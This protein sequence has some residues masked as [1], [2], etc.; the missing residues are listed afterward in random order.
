MC[1]VIAFGNTMPHEDPHSDRKSN[2]HKL[3]DRWDGSR[4]TLLKA[5]GASAVTF[6]ALGV[7]TASAEQLDRSNWS[8]SASDVYDS[9]HVPAYAIGGGE[10]WD[11]YSSGESQ[12]DGLWFEVDLGS[13]N[14]FDEL[15]MDCTDSGYPRNFDVQVSDDGSS[16]TTVDS[17]S[18][19][20][21]SFTFSFAS[22]TSR[23]FRLLVTSSANGNWLSINDLWLNDT[24]SS[25]DDDGDDGDD[26]DGGSSDDWF[27]VESDGTMTDPEGNHWQAQ[28]VNINGE[29]WVWP[30][31]NTGDADLMMDCWNFNF[32]RVCNIL[33]DQCR[34]N[35][36]F[37]DNNDIQD[38]IDTF[39]AKNAVVMLDEHC[40][41]G[42]YYEDWQVDEIS[43]YF[44][45]WADANPDNPYL[46][47][48]VANEPGGSDNDFDLWESHVRQI[49]E[50]VR[51]AG[52]D[53][54]IA[55]PGMSWGQDTGGNWSCETVGESD[56]FILDRGPSIVADYDNVIMD[57][58]IYDQWEQC[59]SKLETFLDDVQSKG[60]HV[61]AGE[62]GV[63]NNGDVSDAFDYFTNLESNYD[64]LSWAAWHWYGGDDNELCTSGDPEPGGYAIDDCTS[65]SNLTWF[66]EEIWDMTH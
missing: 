49:I 50:D 5:L 24:G 46:W 21:G 57:F 51:A 28:G 13:E 33:W 22:Q 4:R 45:E 25:D 37:S 60:M 53:H 52:H 58:H 65:P 63:D 9:G 7:G 29:E 11:Y 17:G 26:G 19:S 64:N 12:Y 43:D 2:E 31:N 15:E 18:A 35:E 41:T 27:T 48:E 38:K 34:D 30:R 54:V 10:S 62:I 39:T 56:S 14:T 23:Y 42:G 20:S 66:G 55:V 47:F 1:L 61:L 36:Q 59:E 6:G 32:L 44:I 3:I 8:A 40:L 16:W